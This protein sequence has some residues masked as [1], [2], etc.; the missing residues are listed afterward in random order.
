MEK[1]RDK[2]NIRFQKFI[3]ANRNIPFLKILKE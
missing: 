2:I 3:T 1:I